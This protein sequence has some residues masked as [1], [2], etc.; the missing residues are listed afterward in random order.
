MADKKKTYGMGLMVTAYGYSARDAS[1]LTLK[2][3][4]KLVSFVVAINRHFADQYAA[5]VDFINCEVYA[6]EDSTIAEYLVKGIPVIVRGR[7]IFE[8][9]KNDDKDKT[10]IHPKLKVIAWQLLPR[11]TKSTVTKD[12][13]SDEAYF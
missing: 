8:H 7:L 4:G 11:A 13:N 10:P 9:W 5:D 2:S 1:E 3:K 12:V 6:N